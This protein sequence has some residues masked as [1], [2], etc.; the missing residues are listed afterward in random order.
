MWMKY[1]LIVLLCLGPLFTIN[2][3]GK[4]REPLK[5]VNAIA[6]VIVAAL[7]VWGIAVYWQC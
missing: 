3:I 7:L 1:L 4:P 2:D 6:S 5:P